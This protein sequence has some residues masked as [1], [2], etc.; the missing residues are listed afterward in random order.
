[1]TGVSAHQRAMWTRAHG[2]VYPVAMTV[3]QVTRGPG[4]RSRAGGDGVDKAAH[5]GR[6]RPRA[7][8]EMIGVKWHAARHGDLRRRL[9]AAVARDGFDSAA[10]WLSDALARRESELSPAS[11]AHPLAG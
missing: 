7:T 10:D 9:R 2:S 6:V 8:V 3:E 5:G 1:M 4:T 11:A